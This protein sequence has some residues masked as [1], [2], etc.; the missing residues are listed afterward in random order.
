M[1]NDQ[2]SNAAAPKE[3][4]FLLTE[5]EMKLIRR[6]RS[7]HSGAHLAIIQIDGNGV[8]S[9]SLLG[10]GSVEKLRKTQAEQV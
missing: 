2:N 9:L 8:S 3:G 1:A 10:T 6:I 4:L 5:G 7:L